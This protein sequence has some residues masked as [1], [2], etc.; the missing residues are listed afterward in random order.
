MMRIKKTKT[1]TEEKTRGIRDLLFKMLVSAVIGGI[2]GLPG[3]HLALASAHT[4]LDFTGASH[5]HIAVHHTAGIHFQKAER[6]FR[7]LGSSRGR[8]FPQA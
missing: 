1:T 3:L 2:L 6:S 5:H 8:R 4:R 7:S